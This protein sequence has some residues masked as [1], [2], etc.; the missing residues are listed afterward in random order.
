MLGRIGGAETFAHTLGLRVAAA[1]GRQ[2]YPAQDGLVGYVPLGNGAVD[3]HRG[4][5]DH[6]RAGLAGD[7]QHRL[8]AAK[9]RQRDV[10][11]AL[12]HGLGSR[13]GGGMQ[14]EVGALDVGHVV[15]QVASHKAVP[16]VAV[17]DGSEL[18]L[19]AGKRD[20]LAAQV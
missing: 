13:D 8:G 19:V 3:L 20:D 6:A 2:V 9:R 18:L 1:R 11:G 15:R 5:V 7:L 12:D 4:D 14:D 10:G 17:E 16:A